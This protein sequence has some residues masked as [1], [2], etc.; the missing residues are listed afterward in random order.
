MK[1]LGKLM[2]SAVCLGMTCVHAVGTFAAAPPQKPPVHT[3]ITD[4]NG[5]IPPKHAGSTDTNGELPPE[6]V[7][8]PD[9]N[10]ELPPGSEPGMSRGLEV[11]TRSLINAAVEDGIGS[12]HL[13]GDKNISIRQAINVTAYAYEYLYSDHGYETQFR[14]NCIEMENLTL[15]KMKNFES[16]DISEFDPVTREQ[17]IHIVT[18]IFGADVKGS[19]FDPAGTRNGILPFE[20]YTDC[21]EVSECYRKNVTQALLCGYVSGTDNDMLLPKKNAALTDLVAMVE[22]AIHIHKQSHPIIIGFMQLRTKA[23]YFNYRYLQ[24]PWYTLNL[25]IQIAIQVLGMGAAAV[26]GINKLGEKA[27]RKRRH[28]RR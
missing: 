2:L 6:I 19:A 22:R 9:M 13:Y 15:N 12:G 25:A 26:L 3:G 24:I 14:E 23:S 10:G 21:N 20:Q 4:A 27:D 11:D 1:K 8:R 18:S 7:G 16:K 17:V 28:I 5:E